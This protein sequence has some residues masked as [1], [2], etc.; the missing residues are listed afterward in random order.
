MKIAI[1]SCTVWTLFLS[2]NLRIE[3]Q[4]LLEAAT[5]R[6][7]QREL[8]KRKIYEG[9]IDGS[10]SKQLQIALFKFQEKE[11]LNPSG[12]IDKPTL[13]AL[14][15]IKD[16]KNPISKTVE[17]AVKTVHTA[18]QATLNG[19]KSISKGAAKSLELAGEKTV[20]VVKD[21]GKGVGQGGEIAIDTVEKA[22]KTVKKGVTTLGKATAEGA[23]TSG[24]RVTDFLGV[25]HSDTK[26]RNTIMRN[27]STDTEL[28]NVQI[29]VVADGGI[30]TLTFKDS[31]LP[32]HRDRALT[33]ARAVVGVENVK[34]R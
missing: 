22:G 10:F 29:Y 14:G 31:S 4:E 12:V 7:V 3:S 28:H 23:K 2:L 8:I 5:N 15:I 17:S 25:G 11:G 21:T 19:T 9:N 26:I 6:T 34:I 1:I 33:I 30:V 27:F 20:R 13:I 32:E 16:N 24:D 18:G